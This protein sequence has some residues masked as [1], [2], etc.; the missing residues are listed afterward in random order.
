MVN[1]FF[2]GSAV[3][4]SVTVTRKPVPSAYFGADAMI[5][6]MY[7]SMSAS[8]AFSTAFLPKTKETIN[9]SLCGMRYTRTLFLSFIRQL[10]PN[11]EK[12]HSSLAAGWLSNTSCASSFQYTK[13]FPNACPSSLLPGGDDLSG[14]IL[15]STAG[16][17]K[18]DKN[19]VGLCSSTIVFVAQQHADHCHFL[20]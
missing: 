16:V 6:F 19:G 4:R 1:N 18:S 15:G 14:N 10:Q 7:C 3:L 12:A 11:F 8:L 20:R 5:S 17:L 9:C 13:D 2:T